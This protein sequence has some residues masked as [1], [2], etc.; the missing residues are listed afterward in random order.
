[1]KK[2]I[3]ALLL[4]AVILGTAVGC[5]DTG[6]SEPISYSASTSESRSSD[7][8]FTSSMTSDTSSTT[9]VLTDIALNVLNVKRA[10][11]QGEALDLTGLVVT[12][13]YSDG[14]SKPVTD[15]T[16]NPTNG[17]ALNTIGETTVTVTYGGYSKS[18]KVNVSQASKK[19]WTEEEAKIMKDHL[20]GEVLPYT[21]DENSVVSYDTEEDLVLIKG[22]DASGGKLGNY[23]DALLAAG[24]ARLGVNPVFEKDVNT[25]IGKRYIRVT[26]QIE[27]DEFLIRAYDPYYYT[28]PTDFAK[29]I[30]EDAFYSNDVPPA[31]EGAD[32][33]E[34]S[35]SNLAIFCYTGS[36]TAESRYTTTL[37]Q[38]GWELGA[39]QYKE[40]NYAVSPDG[41]YAVYYKYNTQY[42]SLDIYFGALYYWNT[43]VIQD[44]YNKYN[45]YVVDIPA[46][47]VT[48]GEYVFVESELNEPAYNSGAY[49]AI[50][51]FMYIYGANAS[52]LP[53]YASTLTTAGWEVEGSNNFYK[54]YLTIP[55]QGVARLEFEYSEKR[56]AV[57]VTIYY[58]LDPIM[59]KEWPEDEINE[60]LGDVVIGSLPK[61]TG[62]K[63]GFTFLNDMF[64]TAVVIHVEKGTEQAAMNYY[65]NTDLAAAGYVKN[66][67]GNYSA[68]DSEISVNPVIPESG[69]VTIEFS[70]T[71]YLKTFPAA[72]VNMYLKGDDT[73]PAYESD[74][75][76]PRAYSYD[77]VSEDT[78]ALYCHFEQGVSEHGRLAFEETLT[79]AG[80]TKSNKTFVS[81][82][83]KLYILLSSTSDYKQLI[84][85]VR[86]T[87]KSAF[88]SLWPT[89]QIAQLF[90]AEGY[91]DQLPSYDKVCNEISCGKDYDGSLYVLIETNDKANVKA[92]YCGLLATAQFVKD[93]INSDEFDAIYKS[94]NNQYTATVRTNQLGV[95]IIIKPLG[96][97]QQGGSTFPTEDIYGYF[98][99]ADGV[100][101]VFEDA[102]ATF[103][104]EYDDYY[105]SLSVKITF[106]TEALA[107]AAYNNYVGQL[108]TANF[109]ERV[110]WGGYAYIYYAPDNSFIVWAN[111]NYLDDGEIYID[112]YPGNTDYF[113]AE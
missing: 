16:A 63:K 23:Q 56:G 97:G 5:Q 77:I 106:E 12:A 48:G 104:S 31:F 53:G 61:Y 11:E 59:L 81:P 91:T 1:M 70:K 96:G 73:V 85:N 67:Y 18:F 35:T 109:R 101:P 43:K 87:P 79:A 75:Y 39:V 9:V 72:A 64:G 6:G 111:H 95:A 108:K 17:T 65:I 74:A 25:S 3:K 41:K 66:E 37:N 60:V 52:V 42:G 7:N 26:T 46:F 45:G 83:K 55:N 105:G 82:N 38:A 4:S 113:P 24:Y 112:I 100:L 98:P 80:Y 36:T 30:A 15:Y 22:G 92:E 14:S 86:G 69:M 107:T 58:Q 19:T 51:A 40:H 90:T 71:G 103:S 49:E 21:G 2:I 54:A 89:Q 50:H 34:T 33:Y 20:Y 57:I 84:I 13:K 68:P 88:E 102:N 62:Q 44:F 94:P 27:D 99:T 10:Y 28:F 47:N 8:P 32:Y 78:I 93:T 76:V 29:M 110:L